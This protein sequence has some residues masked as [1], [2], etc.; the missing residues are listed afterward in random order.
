MQRGQREREG[1]RERTDTSEPPKSRQNQ[2]GI[3][4]QVKLATGKERL[5]GVTSPPFFRHVA[6]NCV[7]ACLLEML[8]L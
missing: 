5:L 3:R 7:L 2:R 4:A 1:D 6:E 8:L